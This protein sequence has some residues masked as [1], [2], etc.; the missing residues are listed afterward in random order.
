DKGMGV[1]VNPNLHDYKLPTM[2][3]IPQVQAGA[4]DTV[5][6]AT[7]VGAKGIGEPPMIPTAAAIANAIYNATGARIRELPITPDKVLKALKG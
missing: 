4:A 7:H 1:L 6:P 3:D 2:L 5:D